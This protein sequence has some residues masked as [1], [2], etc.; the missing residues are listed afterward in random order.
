MKDLLPGVRLRH[1]PMRD[2][3]D[4]SVTTWSEL[5]SRVELLNTQHM[6]SF[7]MPYGFDLCHPNG[8]TM[9]VG[10]GAQEW[11]IT[12][13]KNGDEVATSLGNVDAKGTAWI[14]FEQASE[15]PRRYFVPRDA[16]VSVV[17]CFVETGSLSDAI[18]WE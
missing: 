4:E 14:G 2:V 3:E 1:A 9:T 16:A 17:R 5:S 15:L 10:M 8:L 7:N 13:S 18:R 11:F 12:V 6:A